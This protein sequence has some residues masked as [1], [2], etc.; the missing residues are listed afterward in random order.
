M[1]CSETQVGILY[2]HCTDDEDYIGDCSEKQQGMPY[3]HCTDDKDYVGDC[4]ETQDG[5]CRFIEQMTRT[6]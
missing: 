2:N 5:I 3:I 6:I 4:S 1:D